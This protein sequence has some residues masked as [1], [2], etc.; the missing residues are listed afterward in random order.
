MGADDIVYPEKDMGERVAR[1]LISSNVIDFLE[2]SPEVCIIEIPTP[3]TLVGKSLKEL[4]LRHKYGVTIISIKTVDGKILAPPDIDYQ[5]GKD[6]VLI[7]IGK[8]KL[9]KKLRFT[10]EIL[11][12]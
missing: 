10:E 7:L 2:V 3:D 6:D 8:N 9:L 1:N 4:N 12:I 5:F 11:S